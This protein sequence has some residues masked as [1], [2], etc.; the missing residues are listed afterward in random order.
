LERSFVS[1]QYFTTFQGFTRDGAFSLTLRAEGTEYT[2]Q[3]LQKVEVGLHFGA[4][5][6]E[7]L[8]RHV[9]ED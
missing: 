2:E 5:T 7:E 1:P 8:R 6:M 4:A 9:Q 3:G